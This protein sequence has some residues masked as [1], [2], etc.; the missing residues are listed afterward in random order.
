[1]STK[2]ELW[3]LLEPGDV[4][5]EGDQFWARTIKCEWRGM[6][7]L[8]GSV[9][10][11]EVGRRRMTLPEPQGWIS[12]KERMPTKEDSG[13][14]DCVL[15]MFAS[16]SI[17]A[18]GWDKQWVELKATHWMSI[19]PAPKEPKEPKDPDEEAWEKAYKDLDPD[20]T[21]TQSAIGAG[22]SAFMAGRKSAA[23]EGSSHA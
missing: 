22:K 16:K 1:M 13:A 12:V 9:I 21:W 20:Q 5:Q 7:I 23:A 14:Q 18:A 19:P 8:G 15:W 3:R 17:I 10:E 2:K 6:T 4:W 11:G